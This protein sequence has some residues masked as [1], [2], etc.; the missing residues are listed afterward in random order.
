MIRLRSTTIG[1]KEWSLVC[2]ALGAGR[3]SLILRKGGIAEGRGGFHWQVRQFVLFPT[4]FHE[5]A[6]RII[7]EPTL[8]ARADLENTGKII[9]RFAAEIERACHI[10]QWE[11]AAALAP[12]HVWREEI[13]RE[14]FGFGEQA[15]L[16]VALVRVF[17][18]AEPWLLEPQ[19]SF[20]GCRSWVDLPPTDH[21]AM[22]P[23][24]D[25]ETHRLREVEI[26]GILDAD[27][28]R[29]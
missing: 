2:D 9:I 11:T 29:A 28:S 23:V 8:Q 13:V 4:H 18:L 25:A 16:H 15:G 10:T 14:R 5:Q 20:G 12:F 21:P 3:Q 1:F 26:A 7:W 6:Q 27:G 17:R 19:R 22:R 24:C